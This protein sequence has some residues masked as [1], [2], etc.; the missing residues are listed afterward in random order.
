M[1][2]LTH[3]TSSDRGEYEEDA[4]PRSQG[5]GRGAAAAGVDPTLEQGENAE[6]GDRT[7]ED[8]E[9]EAGVSLPW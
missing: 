6:A 9:R 2:R 5:R 7:E 3:A 1:I 4:D 8:E